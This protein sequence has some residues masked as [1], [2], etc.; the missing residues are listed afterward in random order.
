[1][2]T[3]TLLIKNGIARFKVIVTNKSADKATLPR[4]FGTSAGIVKHK[5]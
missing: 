4:Y 2:T 3:L 5:K 1:M